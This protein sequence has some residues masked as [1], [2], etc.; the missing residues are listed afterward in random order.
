MKIRRFYAP[1]RASGGTS[2]QT[3]NQRPKTSNCTRDMRLKAVKTQFL[4]AGLWSQV[5]RVE[6]RQAG[7]A[8]IRAHP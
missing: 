8:D 3:S 7:P 1:E 2:S 6:Q 4:V 5:F